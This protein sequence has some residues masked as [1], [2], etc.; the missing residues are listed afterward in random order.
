MA[1]KEEK[2]ID[3]RNAQQNYATNYAKEA[4]DD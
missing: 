3:E 1:E 2:V 4:S